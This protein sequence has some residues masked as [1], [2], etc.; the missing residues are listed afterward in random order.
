M[1]DSETEVYEEDDY[2]KQASSDEEEEEDLRGSK[3]DEEE[4]LDV[5]HFDDSF[6]GNDEEEQA[7]VDILP[8]KKL[9]QNTSLVEKVFPTR[10]FTPL[11]GKGLLVL[12]EKTIE[13]SIDVLSAYLQRINSS[14]KPSVAKEIE[15]KIVEE[16]S[17]GGISYFVNEL[18]KYLTVFGFAKEVHFNKLLGELFQPEVNVAN[19]V[20][21]VTDNS[22]KFSDNLVGQKRMEIFN[23][24]NSVANPTMRTRT[25]PSTV[26]RLQP[27]EEVVLYVP[28][29]TQMQEEVVMEEQGAEIQEEEEFKT[30]SDF[31]FFM[32]VLD[33]YQRN[34]SSQKL[35]TFKPMKKDKS[36]FKHDVTKFEKI[37]KDVNTMFRIRN[38]NELKAKED[39]A[40]MLEAERKRLLALEEEAKLKVVVKEKKKPGRPPGP[41]K[42]S[43]PGGKQYSPTQEIIY[44]TFC[45][46]AV[47]EI[48]IRSMEQSKKMEYDKVQFCSFTCLDNH[49]FQS[50]K[51]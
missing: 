1:S 43:K 13:A 42:G 38:A 18:A 2:M 30:S 39:E 23:A 34:A 10:R 24:M 44:C 50:K 33:K 21:S 47:G 7:V 6:G 28:S 8:L 40:K 26:I 45:K 32:D 51:I 27:I 25:A 41:S 31:V 19:V 36:K 16:S 15:T 17:I 5:A 49:K 35:S 11:A 20:Q 22:S 12:N 4:E 14:I 29:V 46:I 9:K 3:I 37:Q 48:Q